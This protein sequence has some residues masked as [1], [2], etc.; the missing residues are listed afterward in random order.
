M[1]HKLDKKDFIIDQIDVGQFY[2]FNCDMES[3]I[4][5]TASAAQAGLNEYLLQLAEH[6]EEELAS[7]LEDECYGSYEKQVD[8][9]YKATRL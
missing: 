5:P 4:Y 9:L 3:E 1:I 8:D 7:R 2:F 6:R